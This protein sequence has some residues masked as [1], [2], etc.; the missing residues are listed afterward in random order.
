MTSGV[1]TGRRPCAGLCLLL[2][3]SACEQ[4]AAPGEED[5]QIGFVR[6]GV[7]YV[8]TPR[9]TQVRQASDGSSFLLDPSWSPDGRF[10]AATQLTQ[11]A[12]GQEDYQV[13][14]VDS[15]TGTQRA[16]TSGPDDH[17][18]VAWSPDGTRIA[19]LGAAEFARPARLFIANA[20]GTQARQVGTGE[21]WVSRPSWSPDGSQLAMTLYSYDIAIVDAQSGGVVRRLTDDRR[22]VAPAWSPDGSTIAFTLISGHDSAIRLMDANG[23]RQR[24]LKREDA[25]YPAW[26]P[27]GRTIAFISSRGPDPD[28]FTIRPDGS[29]ERP[30]T[31]GGGNDM[32]PSWRRVP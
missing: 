11:L 10:A 17:F 26:S 15:R 21:Y 27:D 9:T 1:R 31:R 5:Y 24:T 2:L 28:I 6:D 30:V 7:L 14:V 20:D 19:Y 13:V 23:T 16:I 8:T 29:G 12:G 22:S 25:F 32:G 3:L 4:V 18:G